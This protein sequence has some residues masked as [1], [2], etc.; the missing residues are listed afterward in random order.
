MGTFL[1]IVLLAGIVGLVIWRMYKEKKQGRSSCGKCNGCANA[2]LCHTHLSK[3]S[4][5]SK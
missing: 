2:A 4:S 5:T 3:K 1:V